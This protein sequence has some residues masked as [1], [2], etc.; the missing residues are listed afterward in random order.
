MFHTIRSAS[1]SGW[2]S[3]VAGA[4]LAVASATSAHADDALCAVTALAFDD[5]LNTLGILEAA[6]AVVQG[7]N[8]ARLCARDTLISQ[9]AAAAACQK[10]SD[11]QFIA[12]VRR[13]DG[14]DVI[15]S[16]NSK[17]RFKEQKPE[18][19]KAIIKMKSCA[20]WLGQR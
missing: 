12:I 19:D 8:P 14:V 2:K 9:Q 4:V 16:R 20:Y 18:R 5:N 1:R 7:R 10:S 3:L 6:E 15:N 17:V 11:A 13:V